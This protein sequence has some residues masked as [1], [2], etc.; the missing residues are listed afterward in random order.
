[1]ATYSY[2][3]LAKELREKDARLQDRVVEIIRREV[4]VKAP[5]IIQREIAASAPRQPVDRGT[6]RRSFRFEDV[7]GGATM[8]NFSP[9]A[10]IIEAGRR[11]GARMP[12]L[13]VILEWVRRKRIGTALVGPVRPLMGPERRGKGV[14]RR[15]ARKD[16]VE[17]QQRWIALQIARKIKARG[18]PAHMIV[19]HA[20]EIVD[21]GIRRAVAKL[22]GKG[23]AE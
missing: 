6:Y 19:T 8:Y 22:L 12:P 23:G 2:G 17:R 14:R 18:L 4:K 20:S 9:H 7:R 11:P 10:P 21:D 5:R 3:D 15:S 13:D 1:M 16:A